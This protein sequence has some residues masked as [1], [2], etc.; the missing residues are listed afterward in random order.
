LT[1]QVLSFPI[2]T[3][4][5]QAQLEFITNHIIHFINANK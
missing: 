3:E 2:H 5:E 4:M 1:T